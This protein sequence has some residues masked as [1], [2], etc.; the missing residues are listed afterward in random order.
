MHT[1]DY[2]K[3]LDLNYQGA[4][5]VAGAMVLAYESFGSYQGDWWVLVK[6]RGKTGW[7]QGSFGS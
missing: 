1:K 5:E 3:Y 7:I 4:L 6:F 2:T